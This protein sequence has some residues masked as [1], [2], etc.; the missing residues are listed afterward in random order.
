MYHA[1][2]PCTKTKT[3][4]KL[5][6]FTFILLLC[7]AVFSQTREAKDIIHDRV[8]PQQI[9]LKQMNM[10]VLL[11]MD[12]FPNEI[13]QFISPTREWLLIDRI[14][15]YM[16]IEINSGWKNT[17]T[18]FYYYNANFNLDEIIEKSADGSEFIER[19]R[20]YYDNSNALLLEKRVSE[21]DSSEWIPSKKI[22]Y[23]YNVNND[24][25][26]EELTKKWEDGLYINYRKTTYTYD[27]DN[28]LYQYIT[29][30]SSDGSNWANSARWT[31]YYDQNGDLY[32][33]TNET[34]DSDESVWLDFSRNFLTRDIE[35]GNLIL[36][37]SE[38]WDDEENYW[39]E[40]L[41]QT[42]YYND[43]DYMTSFVAK[44]WDDEEDRWKPVF[45]QVY[46]YLPAGSEE[47][48]VLNAD[49]NK[50]INDFQT[51]ED[52]IVVSI[53]KH[54]SRS[55]SLMGIEVMLDSVLHTSDGDLEFTLTHNGITETIISHAGGD[56]D[57]FINTK[58]SDRGIDSVANGIAP[59]LGI[60]LAENPLSAF[61]TT[62][63]DG[64][65]TLSIYDGA[66]GNTG[67]LITW[68]L[69]FIYAE[70]SGVEDVFTE[71]LTFKLFPNPAN[72]VVNLQFAVNSQQLSVLEIHDLNGR[73]L[74]ENKNLPASETVQIDVS[75][76]PSGM[77][78]CSI[79]TENKSITKK[80]IIQK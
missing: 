48:M 33:M 42:Y 1:L 3:M 55:L 59:F 16:W 54:H 64:I 14:Y 5:L 6:Q 46:T 47:I 28:N 20:Y 15:N 21:Y 35:T 78:M 10:I 44:S 79:R 37:V 60:F 62:D 45:S 4:K 27:N 9:P 51:T 36:M 31:Y 65:W 61:L 71:D 58:L 53:S 18:Y 19:N 77:Y 56:G 70:N 23:T 57:N 39:E 49:I 25:L 73:K 24:N 34:W 66:E 50:P 75:G 68:G 26:I 74:I 72:K 76:L 22:L 80:L 17:T 41:R 13:Q 30:Y 38:Y 8:V 12:A 32:K 63:P 69:N 52:E 29:K 7:S 2:T 11:G 40:R 43:D 67:A